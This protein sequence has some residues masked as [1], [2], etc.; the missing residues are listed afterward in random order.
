LDLLRRVPYDNLFSFVYSERPHTAASVK[1][2]KERAA[3]AKD[4]AWAEVPH[5]TALRRLEEVHALQFART[6]ERHRGAVGREVEVL[7]ES[8]RTTVG[9][10]GER[11]G[12]SRE[13]W[14]VHFQGDCGAGDLVRVHISRASLVALSGVEE[15]VTDPAPFVADNAPRT[16][17]A[18]LSS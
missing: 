6:L 17:L 8:A 14:T 11:F 2:S 3:V 5:E 7:V 4:P 16:R 10:P 18:V 12:R 15:R 9:V 13:N 1:L